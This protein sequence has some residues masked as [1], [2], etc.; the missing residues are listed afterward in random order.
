M[1]NQDC[2]GGEQ[3]SVVS[4]QPIQRRCK[5]RL[6]LV[7]RPTTRATDQ[8]VNNDQLRLDVMHQLDELGIPLERPIGLNVRVGVE[9]IVNLLELLFELH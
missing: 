6:V 5:V 2:G 8:R 9:R 1:H 3:N 4:G 7:K